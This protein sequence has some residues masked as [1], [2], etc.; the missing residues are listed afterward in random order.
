MD[1]GT[2]NDGQ[3]QVR[4]GGQAQVTNNYLD[5]DVILIIGVEKLRLRVDSQSLRSASKVFTAMF[6]PDW[7]E[8][9]RMSAEELTEIELPENDTNAML[10]V[11]YIL[12][13][14]EDLVPEYLPTEEV[15]Q[16]AIV[17]DKYDL[18][19]ALK[20]ASLDWLL[21]R[22]LWSLTSMSETGQLMAAAFLFDDTAMFM[23][24][25]KSLILNRTES[26]LGLG[27]DEI[28]SEVLPPETLRT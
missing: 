5:G 8:G 7:R 18:S 13:E 9:K 10:R 27:N 28:V 3:S 21:P 26:Y 16:I 17:A 2:R 25:S 19:D 6:G 1:R 11:C 24:H 23:L 20:Y 14:R 15:L 4:N 12:H 22:T